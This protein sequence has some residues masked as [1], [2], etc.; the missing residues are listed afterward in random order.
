MQLWP[1]SLN[2][3]RWVTHYANHLAAILVIR[4]ASLAISME[5][6]GNEGHKRHVAIGCC[7]PGP[8]R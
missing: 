4:G 7:W 8:Q 3:P 2:V 1:L 5:T 6:A